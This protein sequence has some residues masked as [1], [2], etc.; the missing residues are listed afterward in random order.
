[1]LTSISD[2]ALFKAQDQLTKRLLRYIIPSSCKR[3]NASV[4]AL[5]NFGSIVKQARV[6]SKEPPIFLNCE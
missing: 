2:I 6:Q 1:M 3:T 5:H 4:T